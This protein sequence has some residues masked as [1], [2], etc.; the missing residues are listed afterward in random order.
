MRRA[1]GAELSTGDPGG[2]VKVASLAFLF[3]GIAFSAR[4]G[5][6]RDR[7]PLR[8]GPGKRRAFYLLRV[9]GLA[10]GCPRLY[11]RR[12]SLWR[13]AGGR[14]TGPFDPV[15]LLTPLPAWHSAA[16]MAWRVLYLAAVCIPLLTSRDRQL[17]VLGASIVVAAVI[18][19][20]VFWYA[21]TSVWCFFAALLSTHICCVLYR[22]PRRNDRPLMVA[23]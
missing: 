22:L 3:F 19:H 8:I 7:C 17:W 10:V 23:I 4:L 9:I 11:S 16:G 12:V 14:S 5:S 1:C 15:R 20:L 13:V 18:T 6:F 21:F 2:M